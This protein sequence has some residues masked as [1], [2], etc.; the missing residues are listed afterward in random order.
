MSS[1]TRPRGRL[2]QR[3]YWVRRVLVLGTALALVVG[4]GSLLDRG[5]DGSSGSTPTAV[6]AAG[7]GSPSADA[8]ATTQGRRKKDRATSTPEPPLP[9]PTGLCQPGDITISPVVPR[10]Y[11]DSEVTIRLELATRY[12][13][14]CTWPMSADTLTYKIANR[15]VGDFWSSLDCPGQV[16]TRTLTLRKDTPVW[17]TVTWDSRG[18]AHGCP[19]RSDWALPDWYVVSVAAFDGE[20][21]EVAFRLRRR[22]ESTPTP[23]AE[24]TAERV[25][26]D[27][28]SGDRTSGDRTS[29]GGTQD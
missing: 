20:P 13:P 21:V 25:T 26:S 28:P 22:D 15:K 17:T 12:S 18:S 4:I 9:Q 29:G 5:S 7:E 24:P 8:T 1:V 6:Q 10:A 27:R 23:T 11:G 2:P 14:A 16:P 3:V 19:G